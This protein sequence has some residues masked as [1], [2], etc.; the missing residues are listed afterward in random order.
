VEPDNIDGYSNNTGFPISYADQIA[1]NT[2]LADEAHAR[3]LSVG[4]KNDIEQAEALIS[5]F[6]FAIA[7]DC[8][9]DSWCDQL[10]PFITAGKAVFDAEYT[11]TGIVLSSFCP[12]ANAWNIDAIMKNRDLDAAR[13]PCR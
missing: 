12:Q 6:D 9:F 8:F 10:L 13:W 3:G 5:S 1:Y 11:D 2:W 4:L 7:E